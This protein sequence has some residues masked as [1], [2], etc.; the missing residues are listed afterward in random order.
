MDPARVD[1]LARVLGAAAKTRQVIV[2][3]HDDRLPEAVRRLGIAATVQSVT[4]RER[5][6]VE[7]RETMDPVFAYIDDARAVA[8]TAELPGDVAAR[9]VPGFCR[10]A[11]EAVCMEKVRLRRLARGTPHDEVE[12]VL[13]ANPKTHPLMALALFDDE[14]RTGEVLSRLNRMGKWAADAFQACKEGAHEQF[15]GD[16]VD[17]IEDTKRLA[18]QVRALA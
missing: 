18:A 7:V 11:I 9:V 5:S 2:F 14:T 1:G 3:T 16:L 4:R 8:K 13:T 15:T 17:L 10:A 6:A 12:Q